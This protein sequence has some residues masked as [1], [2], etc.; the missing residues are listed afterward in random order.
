MSSGPRGLQVRGLRRGAS[1][2]QPNSFSA[3]ESLRSSSNRDLFPS[4]GT[5]PS[6]R[7]IPQK[8][9]LKYQQ[10]FQNQQSNYRD[11]VQIEGSNAFSSSR[12]GGTGIGEVSKFRSS[13]SSSSLT[14][15]SQ[16]QDFVIEPSPIKSKPKSATTSSSETSKLKKI[17]S[18]NELANSE[19]SMPPPIE[20]R[21]TS[22]VQQKTST[23]TQGLMNQS[24]LST[25]L[26]T[27]SRVLQSNSE[28][29]IIHVCD[30]ARGVNR[31]FP[32][33]RKTLLAEM[34]S[35]LCVKLCVCVFLSCSIC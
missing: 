28:T 8:P 1:G 2:K 23:S 19:I 33:D 20:Q 17:I 21:L 32:C 13:S 22:P 35:E 7:I 18:D 10:Q 34:R 4:G 5:N 16:Q 11:K 9:N 29:I 3:S 14:S 27:H 12:N 26:P 25:S 31:D 6:S 24:D 30:E 15:S